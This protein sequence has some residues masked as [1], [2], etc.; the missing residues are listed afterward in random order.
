MDLEPIGT[1]PKQNTFLILY[2]G[3]RNEYDIA[4]WSVPP[5]AWLREDG[6]PARI[7]PTHWAQLSAGPVPLNETR[8]ARRPRMRP[9]F[10]GAA[11][12]T[13]GLLGW[14]LWSHPSVIDLSF[15]QGGARWLVE[16]AN[17][18]RVGLSGLRTERSQH[19]QSPPP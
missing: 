15:A 8:S 16:S 13:L 7:S 17:Q 4:R 11:L 18:G 1:V 19:L 6:E 5:G 9:V 12:V 2:D 3:L 10:G 14:L